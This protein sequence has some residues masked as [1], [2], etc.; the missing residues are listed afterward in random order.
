MNEEILNLISEKRTQIMVHS[1]I[2]Y[3]LG[4]NI[5]EDYEYDSLGRELAK[6]QKEY[7]DESKAAQYAEAFKEYGIDNCVSGFD[8]P[9]LSPEII[10]KADKLIEVRDSN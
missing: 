8:L 7:P 3:Y 9:Y 2:Y 6:L 5:I 10:E 1:Y 4:D